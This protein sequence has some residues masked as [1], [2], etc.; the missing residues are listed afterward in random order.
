MAATGPVPAGT[1]TGVG[2]QF[3]EG[4]NYLQDWKRGPSRKTVK[5]G[6]EKDPSQGAMPWSSTGGQ[7]GLTVI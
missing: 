4:G 6:P 1:P 7:L 3:G 2:E 5:E